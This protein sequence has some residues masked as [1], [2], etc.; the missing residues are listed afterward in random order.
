MTD[1]GNCQSLCDSCMTPQLILVINRSFLEDWYLGIQIL[2]IWWTSS[3]IW[4]MDCTYEIATFHCDW[5]R[6]GMCS[7]DVYC[8]SSSVIFRVDLSANQSSGK[9][10][11]FSIVRI[12]YIW[13]YFGICS[14]SRSGEEVSSCKI[15]TLDLLVWMIDILYRSFVDCVVAFAV[16]CS[17][18]LYN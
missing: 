16:W 11:L 9:N 10:Y 4:W 17:M 3:Y 5:S 2:S 18:K 15:T 6:L 13:S 8:Y 7:N 1:F 14:R 12:M